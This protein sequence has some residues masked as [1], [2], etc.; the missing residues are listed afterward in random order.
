MVKNQFA[1]LVGSIQ[2][3]RDIFS[4]K[5][6]TNFDALGILKAVQFCFTTKKDQLTKKQHP[7]EATALVNWVAKAK[8]EN[9]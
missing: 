7:P 4:K 5:Q 1:P 9:G 3:N 2:K 6:K 8:R